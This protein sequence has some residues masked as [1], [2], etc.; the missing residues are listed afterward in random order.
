MSLYAVLGD[1]ELEVI[2]WLD[3][4]EGRFG[5]SWAEQGLIGR[6][7]LLQH[8]GFAPDELRIDVLL[9]S[10]WCDPGVELACLKDRLDAA[11]PLA[12]VLGTGEYRG[13]F[14]LTDIETTTRQTDGHGALIAIEARI[15]LRECVGDPA[16]PHPPGVILPGWQAP[17]AGGVDV[18]DVPLATAFAESPVG[19][20]AGA[21][22]AA[23]SAM[24]GAGVAAERLSGLVAAAQIN[25]SDAMAMAGSI[26]GALRAAGQALA[27]A[28][29]ASVGRLMETAATAARSAHGLDRAAAALEGAAVADVLPR[30]Q[31]A[32]AE[33]RSALQSMDGVRA[34]L[35]AVAA[36]IATR[37][38]VA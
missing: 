35:A 28:P 27:D 15:T 24:A 31:W 23:L 30:A 37:Q 34:A 18:V 22:S 7:G 20:A 26:G 14:V 5:A 11:E 33:A 17:V 2:Q 6:K 25:A 10:M 21:V 9:H 29:L 38:E 32:L 16:E 13:T 12:F 4:F 3:G 19:V 1:T 8:T 36:E